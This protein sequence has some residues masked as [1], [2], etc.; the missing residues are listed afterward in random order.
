MN[1]KINREITRVTSEELI[2]FSKLYGKFGALQVGT[3]NEK[4][5]TLY[6]IL[7]IMELNF[8]S[9]KELKKLK[10]KS[11]RIIQIFNTEAFDKRIQRFKAKNNEQTKIL[12]Q[13]IDEILKEKEKEFAK[14]E[15]LKMY[16]KNN[17]N[18]DLIANENIIL[19]TKQCYCS[20]TTSRGNVFI[21]FLQD[22]ASRIFVDYLFTD[23]MPTGEELREWLMKTFPDK[24][25]NK[26]ITIIQ[27][28]SAG[29]Y[30][31]KEFKSFCESKNIKHSIGQRRF[32][33]QVA[34]SYNKLFWDAVERYAIKGYSK[35]TFLDYT[36]E[37]QVKIIEFCI[38]II[39][40]NT[41]AHVKRK[42]ISRMKLHD[43][44]LMSKYAGILFKARTGT[45]KARL[46]EE[47]YINCIL[48]LELIEKQNLL[49]QEY[50]ICIKAENMKI[51]EE[52]QVH[53]ITMN[54]IKAD[55][56]TLE[57]KTYIIDD[58]I[59]A[60][61]NKENIK[62]YVKEVL[63]KLENINLSIE[64][65]AVLQTSIVGILQQLNANEVQKEEFNKL[66]EQNKELGDKLNLQTRILK[67]I[68]EKQKQE[69]EIRKE[70]EQKTLRRKMNLK[71]QNNIKYSIYPEDIENI[72]KCVKHK[73]KIQ[74]SKKKLA[75]VILGITGLRIGNLKYVKIEHFDKLF[76]KE[77]FFLRPIKTRKA[78]KIYIPYTKPMKA[79]LNLVKKDYEY[80]KEN[81]KQIINQNNK[82]Q[83]KG[84]QLEKGIN[85]NEVSELYHELYIRRE[86]VNKWL[87]KDLKKASVLL[88]K[89]VTSHSYRR[90][91]AI[92]VGR[93]RGIYTVKKLLNHT[94]I[95]TTEKYLDD[96]MDKKEIENVMWE[97]L[98]VK[99]IKSL[100]STCFDK[101]MTK[102]KL[103]EL[104]D[105][106]IDKE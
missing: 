4:A 86:T 55:R 28:D 32:S 63:E 12:L 78:R 54:Q 99:D 89:E 60:A 47:C 103:E 96:I 59:K 106:E 77:G 40:S 20:D 15:D 25:Y 70:K 42:K 81:E 17:N 36:Y 38:N 31:S 85:I 3:V 27:T 18:K 94:S 73:I 11:I 29:N 34:E 10:S 56:K 6:E 22:M 23:H 92:I 21:T 1:R 76:N 98:S 80:I 72:L 49:N 7:V 19:N 104:I 46:I 30:I 87:N 65:K 50:G 75:H 37:M 35:D 5:Q 62:K 102:E 95:I 16:L 45:W 64:N 26:N 41:A 43:S 39:N 91:I 24:D 90:G 57:D 79:I 83:L 100:D 33:N 84:A 71:K 8:I 67:E 101:S 105:E 9:T 53:E 68:L 51:K 2:V 88:N 48:R 97:A 14:K 69:I 82:K 44:L 66:K 13:N 52:K 61:G 58:F 93:L 74:E